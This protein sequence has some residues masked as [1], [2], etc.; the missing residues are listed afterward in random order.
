MN[1]G[2]CLSRPGRSAYAKNTLSILFESSAW[3][4]I[5]NWISNL[6]YREG[7]EPNQ[8]DDRMAI[9]LT[10][11]EYVELKL[12][13]PKYSDR[14]FVTAAEHMREESFPISLF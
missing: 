6:A 3:K 14:A 5:S 13:P 11:E 1:L 2:D 4:A 7:I 9:G 12:M 8:G 10:F